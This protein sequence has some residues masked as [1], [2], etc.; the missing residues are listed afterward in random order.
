MKRTQKRAVNI[1]EIP[2]PLDGDPKLRPRSVRFEIE[3]SETAGAR[4]REL[5]YSGLYGFTESDVA[6]R[7]I[8]ERLVDLTPK[9]RR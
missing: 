9:S 2:P 3:V 8:Y 7:L 4:M 5:L 1:H 6:Q